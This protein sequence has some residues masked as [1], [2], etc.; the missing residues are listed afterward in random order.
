M[1]IEQYEE[2]KI[3]VDEIKRLGSILE[4]LKELNDHVLSEFTIAMGTTMGSIVITDNDR[5][6]LHNVVKKYYQARLTFNEVEL[7]K[8]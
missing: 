8:I 3:C 1:E 6:R 7:R 5:E 2:A 4:Q